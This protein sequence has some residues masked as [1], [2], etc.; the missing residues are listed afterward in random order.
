[1]IAQR[2]ALYA[3]TA[4]AELVGCYLLCFWLRE[5]KSPL[6]LAPAALS[7]GAFAWLLTPHPSAAG[8]AYAA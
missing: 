2:I 1:M 3:L 6:L 7:L 8:R 5:G 4:L